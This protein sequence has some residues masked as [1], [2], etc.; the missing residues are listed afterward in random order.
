MPTVLV[1]YESN[2]GDR[3]STNWS[4]PRP[5]LIRDEVKTSC[6]RRPLKPILYNRNVKRVLTS[7]L[8]IDT[9]VTTKRSNLQPASSEITTHITT[10]QSPRPNPTGLNDLGDINHRPAGMLWPSRPGGAPFNTQS[11]VVP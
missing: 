5:I 6:T 4:P 2:N 9:L 8:L 11:T 3:A 1:N 10:I 7:L